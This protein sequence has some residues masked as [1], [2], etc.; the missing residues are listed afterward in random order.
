MADILF[1]IS[2]F[3]EQVCVVCYMGV[4]LW[5]AASQEEINSWFKEIKIPTKK[6]IYK[7]TIY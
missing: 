4:Y 5:F 7:T 6:R 2:Y 1:G 3:C